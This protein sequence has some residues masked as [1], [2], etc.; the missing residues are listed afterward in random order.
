MGYGRAHDA[1]RLVRGGAGGLWQ[2]L[3]DARCGAADRADGDLSR[4]A[5]CDG[6]DERLH[7]LADSTIADS[8]LNVSFGATTCLMFTHTGMYGFHCM[9]HGFNG[10][11]VV[12]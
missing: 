1:I 10:T 2:R 11:I 9:P 3:E 12:Q 6:D 8:G 7:V 5:G 4:D